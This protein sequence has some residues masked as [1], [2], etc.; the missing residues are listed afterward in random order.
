MLASN[1]HGSEITTVARK[2]NVGR[3]RD[4]EC[5]QIVCNCNCFI[6]GDNA[7]KFRMTKKVD[8]N[9]KKCWH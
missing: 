5:L 3:K 9:T 4:I 2:D 1:N 6:G 7:D 8:K